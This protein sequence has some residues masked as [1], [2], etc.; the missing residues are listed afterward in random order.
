MNIVVQLLFS[1]SNIFVMGKIG[2][3]LNGL[4]LSNSDQHALT[5]TSSGYV[6]VKVI[7]LE[8]QLGPTLRLLLSVYGIL[9]WMF[10]KSDSDA[11]GTGFDIAGDRFLATTVINF[12][13]DQGKIN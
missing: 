4:N 11:V 9:A 12:G 5:I 13:N 7:P 8:I 1:G 10:A 6:T 2:G 3:Q